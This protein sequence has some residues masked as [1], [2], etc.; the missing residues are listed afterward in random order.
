MQ[1][2]FLSAVAYEAT[3]TGFSA[4]S[5]TLIPTLIALLIILILVVPPIV[6]PLVIRASVKKK[7]ANTARMCEI[8]L[9]DI[10]GQLQRSKND[11]SSISESHREEL[12]TREHQIVLLLKTEYSSYVGNRYEDYAYP[13]D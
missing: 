10:V 6:I 3:D 5:L 13:Y 4:S 7:K 12:I 1:Y 9:N 2:T 8:E 11:S